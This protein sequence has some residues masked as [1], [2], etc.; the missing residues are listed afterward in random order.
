MNYIGFPAET[1]LCLCATVKRHL[2][3]PPFN[4][5]SSA[6]VCS[7]AMT[8]AAMINPHQ[9]GSGSQS[10][11]I[12]RCV[13]GLKYCAKQAL[14][15]AVGVAIAVG[16]TTWA[17]A[18]DRPWLVVGVTAAGVIVLAP[19]LAPS[20]TASLAIAAEAGWAT[21]VK[22]NCVAFAANHASA[23]AACTSSLVNTFVGAVAAQAGAVAEVLQLAAL[24]LVN[25]VAI[26]LAPLYAK[27]ATTASSTTGFFMKGY[28]GCM[29]TS[30]KTCSR[31][32]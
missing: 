28:V 9:F 8:A 7:A 4:W 31:S 1:H 2:L 32:P 17:S 22:S 30:A 25:N 24:Y 16:T 6:F 20:A 21:F 19:I 26:C 12:E 11:A 27:V 10:M 13:G 23:A 18:K 14:E 15:A 5:G 3:L 29:C